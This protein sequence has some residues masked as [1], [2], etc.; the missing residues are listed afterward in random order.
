MAEWNHTGTKPGQ[1]HVESSSCSRKSTDKLAMKRSTKEIAS[2]SGTV[3]GKYQCFL[4]INLY[5]KVGI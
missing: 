2:A 1:T 5:V 4:S 3:H